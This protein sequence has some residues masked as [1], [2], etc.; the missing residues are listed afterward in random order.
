MKKLTL[1]VILA[2]VATLAPA[3]SVFGVEFNV[4]ELLGDEWHRVT[5]QLNGYDLSWNGDTLIITSSWSQF[6]SSGQKIAVIGPAPPIHP[7]SGW[8]GRRRRPRGW[9]TCSKWR[10]PR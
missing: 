3:A 5:E 9:P 2:A 10:R 4:Q 6:Q 1:T 8:A 7:P